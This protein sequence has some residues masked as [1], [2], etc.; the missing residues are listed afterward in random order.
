MN[1]SRDFM[2]HEAAVSHLMYRADQLPKIKFQLQGA[3][4]DQDNTQQLHKAK[5]VA[6]KPRNS[7]PLVQNSNIE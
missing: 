7:V 5:S 1:P 4:E 2:I 3:Y 6:L